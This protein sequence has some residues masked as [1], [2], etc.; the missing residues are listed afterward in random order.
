MKWTST[1]QF[2]KTVHSLLQAKHFIRVFDGNNQKILKGKLIYVTDSGI[3][4]STTSQIL[5]LHASEIEM[6]KTNRSLKT[7]ISN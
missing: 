4:V 1:I 7:W 6:I 3:V 5:E 2:F